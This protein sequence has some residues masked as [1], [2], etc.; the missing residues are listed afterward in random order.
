MA[1][2]GGQP[3]NQN[4]AKG[5]RWQKALERALAH[6]AGSTDEGLFKVA[7]QV[8]ALALGG[9]TSAWTEIANRMDGK[10][11]QAIAAALSGDLNVIREL[12]GQKPD[13]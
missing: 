11:V 2:S 10:P 4:A 13:A 8:V 5:D 9:N 7:Q 12:F 1:T 3:G 6:A